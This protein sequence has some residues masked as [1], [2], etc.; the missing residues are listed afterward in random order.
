MDTGPLEMVLSAMFWPTIIFLMLAPLKIRLTVKTK[1]GTMTLRLKES[2]ACL[3]VMVMAMMGLLVDIA[4]GNA[5]RIVFDIAVL[6][7]YARF[8]RYAKDDEDKDDEDR[9]GKRVARQLGEKSKARVRA[10]VRNLKP[11]PAPRPVPVR[12]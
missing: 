5:P 6:L 1:R 8:Y 9:K 11:A 4:H 2:W 7:L 10:L 12:N 3:T